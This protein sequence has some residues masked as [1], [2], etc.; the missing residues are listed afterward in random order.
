M[1]GCRVSI[2]GAALSADGGVDNAE[3]EYRQLAG[4]LQ[5]GRGAGPLRC[6][7][8]GVFEPGRI[9][10]VLDIPARQRDNRQSHRIGAFRS[11]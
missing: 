7:R 11:P 9:T 5:R 8:I 10:N 3:P 4:R 2:L 6:A 1:T